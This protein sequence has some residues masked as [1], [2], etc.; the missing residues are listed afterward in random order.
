MLIIIYF[1]ILNIS[2]SFLRQ[3]CQ[4]LQTSLFNQA[5]YFATGS[6]YSHGLFPTN[7]SSSNFGYSTSTQNLH[8]QS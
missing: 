2:F 7:T 8:H 5:A 3:D 1:S 4:D 6:V